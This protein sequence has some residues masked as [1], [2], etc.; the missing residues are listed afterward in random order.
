MDDETDTRR[1]QA[2]VLEQSGATVTTAA[3]G[4]ESLQMLER[5]TPDLLL[6][7]IGMLEIDG[8]GLIEQVR[9]RPF[10]R[11]GKIPAGASLLPK[12]IAL[13]AYAGE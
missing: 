3:S 8:Y 12:A 13:T 9:S 10:D 5:S 2:F 1:F 11:G 6:S 7:D 4:F